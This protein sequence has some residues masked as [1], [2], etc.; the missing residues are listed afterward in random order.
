MPAHAELSGWSPTLW[1]TAAFAAGALLQVDRIPLWATAVLIACAAWQL[2]VAARKLPAFPK[3]AQLILTFVLVACVVITFHTVNGLAAGTVLLVVMGSIKLVES[4]SRRDR[5]IVIAAA[6][7]LLLAACLDRQGL[8][9]VPLYLGEV[10]LCCTALAV[11]AYGDAGLDFRVAGKLAGRSLLLAVPLALVL[12]LFFPRLPGGFWALPANDEARTGLGESMSPGSISQLTASYDPAFR[13][14]FLGAIPPARERY[15]R[16]PVLHAFDGYTWRRGAAEAYHAQRLRF[17]GEPYRY[18]VT[19]VGDDNRWWFAL[20]TVADA[21]DKHVFFSYDYDLIAREPATRPTSYDAVSYTRTESSDTLSSYARQLETAL[22][23]DRNPRT[24]QLAA[25]L[26]ARAATDSEFVRAVVDFLRAGGFQYSLTPPKLDPDSVDD[27]LFH[28]REGFCGHFASAFVALVRAGG[29]P[30]RVVT[31]YQ[32][33]EWNPIGGY[34]VIRQ[35]D[36]HAW[37]EVWIDGRGWRRMDPT[38]IVAPERLSRGIL[39]LLPDAVS[40]GTRLLHGTPFLAHLLQ[41]WDALNA[42]WNERIVKFDVN[43]Q[44]GILARFGLQSNDWMALVAAL[45]GGLVGWL[46]W[47]AWHIGRSAGARP[48]DRLGRAYA[49]LCRK[50]A[51]AGVA[52]DASEGPLAYAAKIARC[53]PDLAVRAQPL[54]ARY[55]HLRYG[56]ISGAAATSAIAGFE[57]RVFRWHVARRS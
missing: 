55:A 36:A 44:L 24:R 53:R 34:F 48:P 43:S 6:L 14:R 32:G 17:L 12:F 1:T 51:R 2:S 22:P 41:G 10:A 31:G 47:I 21:S 49:R 39:D 4:R 56:S 8:A 33:G 35:S 13:V 18:T 45:G 9:R 3:L 26:R 5:Y 25:S 57:R 42:A 28:T 29:V 23:A 52:R 16:G 20:D 19:L 50:L 54:L 11:T 27:F 7:F 15:W 30:A 46:A 40:R 37:A 38:A